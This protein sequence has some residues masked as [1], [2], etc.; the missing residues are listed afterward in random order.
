M[1]KTKF[2]RYLLPLLAAFTATRL[3]FFKQIWNTPVLNYLVL[4]SDYYYQWARALAAGYGNPPGV[5]WLSPLYSHFLATVFTVTGNHS[6]LLAILTNAALSILTV[7]LLVL[8]TRRL[9]GEVTALVTAGLCILYSPWLYYDGMLLTASL[10]LAI[11]AALLWVLAKI[12]D[13]SEYRSFLMFMAGV[14]TGLSALARPSILLFAL[15]LIL[16]I[17]FQYRELRTRFL[18]LYGLALCLTVSPVLVRNFDETGSLTLTT[19]AGGINFYIGNRAGAS[20]LYDDLPWV[21]SAD[22]QREAE[23]FRAEASRRTGD[24]LSLPQANRYWGKQALAD[25]ASSPL[26]WAK[27]LLKKGWLTIQNAEFANNLSFNSVRGY[28]PI[29]NALPFRWG[30]LAPLAF[31][32]LLLFW[33]KKLPAFLWLYALAYVATGLIFFCSSEYRLPLILLFIPA[34]AGFF[35]ELWA[36]IAAK[37][38]RFIALACFVYFVALVVINYPSAFAR[39]R[40]KPSMDFQNLGTVAQDNKQYLDAIPLFA[41]A[42]ALDDSLR[43]ARLGLAESLWRVG[44][45]DDARVQFSLAGITPPD[46]LSGSPLQALLEQVQSTFDKLGAESTLAFIEAHFPQGEG[47]LEIALARAKMQEQLKRYAAALVS[48]RTAI[49]LDPGN[50][51]ILHRAGLMAA[52]TDEV[53]LSDS[54]YRAAIKLY[55]A[56]APSRIELGLLS[57]YRGDT[58]SAREQVNELR[59]ISIPDDSLRARFDTLSQQLAHIESSRQ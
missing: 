21:H 31:A 35:V 17:Y 54:L 44:N 47:P 2:I 3:I 49:A 9:F 16:Y 46:T 55:P 27:L 48:Y 30:L 5:F 18:V 57:L 25:I 22:P 26:Q 40:S 38:I 23:A 6:V 29:V 14:L 15:G 51:A 33:R 39:A 13:G 28:A 1:S 41:R 4:D 42:L 24:S 59:K 56:Y 7:T 12:F 43:E 37:Q 36:L 8:T 45:Y 53:L 11:N 10:I 50:P 32:T 20:G 19:A 52:W 34:A 58:E